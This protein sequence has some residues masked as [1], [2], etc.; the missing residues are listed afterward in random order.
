MG[1]N[2]VSTDADHVNL[3]PR[4][5][6]KLKK[7]PA[8]PW[9]MPQFSPMKINNELTFG[10][11]N[12]TKFATPYEMFTRFLTDD[13][14]HA[15]VKHTNDY[16]DLYPPPPTFGARDWQ[17]TTV[18]ELR[19]YIGAYIWMGVHKEAAV[20][21]YWRTDP[22]KGPIHE[23]VSKHISLRRWQQIDR[24]FHIS[25]PQTPA[26]HAKNPESVF[27]KL[28]PLNEHLRC[29][30]KRHWRAGT[31]LT[32]DESI[33]RFTGRASEVVNIPSKPTPEGFKIW[34]L[35]NS[36]YV[37]DWMWHAKGDK[38]GPV[39][40]DEFWTKEEGFSKTQAVVLDL[41]SQQGVADDC[42]HIVWLDN[43][44]TSARLLSLLRDQ[45]FGG[46]GTVRT[47]KTNRE[48]LE[49]KEGFKAQ[50]QHKEVDRGL[51]Y[52]LSELKLIYNAVIPWGALYGCLSN[53]QRVLEFAW[54]DQNV[55]L[56]M[57]TVSNGK[58]VVIRSRRR[59]PKTATNAATSHVVF[60]DKTIKEL[61]IP[62]FIDTYNHFMN[63]VDQADQ[64]RCYYTT[65]RVHLK[66]WKSL[67]HFLL[68]V[69]I[70]NTYKI[71]VPSDNQGFPKARK[72]SSHRRFR[73]ELAWELFNRSERLRGKSPNIRASTLH[74]LVN[75]APEI[76]HGSLMKLGSKPKRC[77]A[78]RCSSRAPQKF[79]RK[80]LMELN[81][82][83]LRANQ[84]RVRASRSI[85]G[86][87]LCRIYLCNHCECWMDH[88]RAISD[89]V[90]TAE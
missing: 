89:D 72:N 80:P 75:G 12:T 5:T 61:A 25:P 7:S 49:E 79:E 47:T 35:A 78:C 90:N 83:S 53:D 65:Q 39:D 42:R 16:A 70:V 1:R 17:P 51:D 62:E 14:L 9:E 58:E 71:V 28:E 64:L 21:E 48:A 69:T 34:I 15:I 2:R 60:G 73:I 76:A 56:F 3:E 55:V 26:E 46:A 23:T 44:F 68:D 54:K 59:P 77:E 33:Q 40:L 30:F 86:C 8:E 4:P 36:G 66:H 27:A 32:V 45:G 38:R 50:K 31:H 24:F 63:G 19:A 18:K 87:G 10:R 13:I 11:P 20:E 41:L 57:T 37:L 84:R 85:Y 82:I 67:W 29:E 74:Q 81:P 43:L 22:S 52:S 6:K 88:I